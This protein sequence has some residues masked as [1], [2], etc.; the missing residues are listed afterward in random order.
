MTTAMQVILADRV[1]A[2]V[3]APVVPDPLALADALAASGIRALE[4][5]FTT[6]GV[7]D[8]LRAAA[9]SSTAVVGL[10]TV[11]TGDQARAAIDSGAQFLV[12]PGVR[13]EVAAV[14]NQRGIPVVMG[15]FTPTEV[16]AALDL[17][18]AAVKIF[19]ARTLGPGYFKDLLGPF[20]GVS[21]IP[22]GGVNAGNA[23]EFLAQGAVAVTAGTDVVPPASVAAGEW[24]E[25]SSR[26]VSF[27]RS[28]S[29]KVYS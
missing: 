20:P 14:A 3:R 28:M 4:L 15:A 21:L 7:L 24:A 10:G 11:V 6:P 27:V 9:A 5:T 22:S 16:L 26:A 29:G 12:T 13:A 8:C 25:I 17:G 2:V 19:P 23:A 18:A 1:L